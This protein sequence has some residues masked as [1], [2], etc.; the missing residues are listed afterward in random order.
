MSYFDSSVNGSGSGSDSGSGS[1]SGSGIAKGAAAASVWDLGSPTLIVEADGQVTVLEAT[2]TPAAAT[3][4]AAT[5]D[6]GSGHR[7]ACRLRPWL[8]HTDH[9]VASFPYVFACGG[10]E[11]CIYRLKEGDSSRVASASATATGTTS[12]ERSNSS[13]LQVSVCVHGR[14]YV[15]GVCRGPAHAHTT[16]VNTF[17]HTL[18][19]THRRGFG[20]TPNRPLRLCLETKKWV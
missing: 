15:V 20:N 18:T 12:R 3:T 11:L 16:H 7:P 6:A 17:T 2:T 9:I 5:A 13:S 1:G 4:A 14:K 19:H 8:S 10:E